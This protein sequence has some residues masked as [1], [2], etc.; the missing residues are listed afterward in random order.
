MKKFER[1]LYWAVIILLISVGYYYYTSV[2]KNYERFLQ[3]SKKAQTTVDSL[4]KINDLYIENISKIRVTVDT[5]NAKL[6]N[7]DKEIVTLKNRVKE[8]KKEILQWTGDDL[9]NYLITRYPDKYIPADFYLDSSIEKLL[10]P[11]VIVRDVT[12]DLVEGDGV[13]EELKLTIDKVNIME[14]KISS[15]DSI[16]VLQDSVNFNCQVSNGIL[17]NEFNTCQVLVTQQNA[18]IQA[19]SDRIKRLSKATI[20]N[21]GIVA[22]LITIGQLIF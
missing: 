14:T 1:I 12:V 20:R 15:L 10:L 13:K 8:S 17:Q 7:K 9:V 6:S 11:E 4:Q 2:D 3:S 5:L 16:I 18:K 21:I 19:Q 22:T